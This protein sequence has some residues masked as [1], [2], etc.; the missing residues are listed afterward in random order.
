[1]LAACQIPPPPITTIAAA[2]A[3]EQELTI[4]AP[5]TKGGLFTRICRPRG[6]G[7][8]RV[9][10]SNHGSP[11]LGAEPQT[12]QPLAC[13]SQVASWF[14]NRGFM[15]VMPLRRGFGRTGGAIAE[16][17]GPCD[18]PDYVRA[19]LAG[20][21]DI[22]AAVAFA[23][24]RPDAQPNHA[25]V[26]G[27]STGGWAALAYNARPHPEIDAVIS[28][29]GGRGAWGDGRPGVNCRPDLLA[30]AAAHFAN[31]AAPPMLWIFALSD[32]WFPP[33][34]AEAMARAYQQAGGK[35]DFVQLQAVQSD[36]HFMFER[37]G[38]AALWGPIIARY[39]AK[40]DERS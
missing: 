39:L 32:T 37:P 5:G 18:A 9:V 1:M 16:S 8:F 35:L 14:L 4:P 13:D 24:S 27:E 3:R 23:I 10:V 15:V 40:A 38:G 26:I 33:P 11:R 31:P 30:Q 25:I 29:A 36:G 22:E 19:G 21:Q 2:P 34:V 6:T 7:P 12:M 17:S 20:A 28:L